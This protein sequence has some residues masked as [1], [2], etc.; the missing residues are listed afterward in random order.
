MSIGSDHESGLT[1]SSLAQ[2]FGSGATSRPGYVLGICTGSLAAA[3]VS[4]SSDLNEVVTTG[5]QAVL[6]AFRVG[7][8]AHRKAQ[9][10]AHNK[11]DAHSWSFA[12]N[13]QEA[14][15]EVLLS[16]LR[17]QEVSASLKTPG[18]LLMTLENSH[19]V[20]A[21]SK[22]CWPEWCDSEWSSGLIERFDVQESYQQVQNG[23]HS[24]LCP[25]SCITSLY[26]RRRQQHIGYSGQRT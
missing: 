16:D 22:R 3:A 10:I 24:N 4:C 14:D 11:G 19:C 13:M 6:V 26:R 23:A 20:V 18:I 21:I 7:M 17:N 15:A 12:I 9:A 1:L 25:I 8:L 5:L 2:S